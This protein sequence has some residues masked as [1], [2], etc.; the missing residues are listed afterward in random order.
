MEHDGS[1][2]FDMVGSKVQHFIHLSASKRF[3]IFISA[4][5]SQICA[6]KT[7]CQTRN[8]ITSLISIDQCFGTRNEV[9]V[10]VRVVFH[11]H[12]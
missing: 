7:V 6:P 1:R 9:K 11:L 4:D 5:W 3:E 2:L 8:G 12:G 10:L